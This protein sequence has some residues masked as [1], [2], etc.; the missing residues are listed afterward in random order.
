V[1]YK[2]YRLKGFT[3]TELMI[4]LGIV[5]VLGMIAFPAYR[6]YVR[7]SYYAEVVQAADNLKN[8]VA[9]CFSELKTFKDCDSG[10]HRIPPETKKPHGSVANVIVKNGI[11][12]ATPLAWDGIL[13]TDTY[14]LTPSAVRNEITWMPSG[15][16]IEHGY[17]G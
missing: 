2:V 11:I 12:T 1:G 13:M 5:C 10:K 17:A 7:R 16:G 9:A 6:D 15:K 4:V 14:I 8:D 3:L